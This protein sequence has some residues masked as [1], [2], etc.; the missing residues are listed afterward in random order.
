MSSVKKSAVVAFLELLKSI[1][2]GDEVLLLRSSDQCA[3][4]VVQDY[5]DCLRDDDPPVSPYMDFVDR[6][7]EKFATAPELAGTEPWIP[8][9]ETTLHLATMLVQIKNKVLH[10]TA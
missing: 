9:K 7:A 4:V 8:E 1:E 2:A 6:L 5:S 3:N 10:P